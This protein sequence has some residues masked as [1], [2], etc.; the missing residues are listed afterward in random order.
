M[1]N[2]DLKA[3]HLIAIN[4]RQISVMKLD[5]I[6][7]SRLSQ[8][9]LQLQK[10][11]RR[12]FDI[13]RSRAKLLKG[14]DK[15]L[16]MM[17]LERGSSFREIARLAGLNETTIARRVRK[18]TQQLLDDRYFLCMRHRDRFTCLELS[19]AKDYLL[20]DLPMTKIA[21]QRDMSYYQIRKT[22]NK[23]CWITATYQDNVHR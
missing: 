4:L 11:C 9:A 7:E 3:E 12:R 21:E 19:I 8:E 14:T 20:L 2:A 16:M 22:V 18:L 13:L 17:Y 10:E 15:I 6:I 23:I 5:K 1:S